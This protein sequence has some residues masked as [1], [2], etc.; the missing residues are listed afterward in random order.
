MTTLIYQLGSPIVTKNQDGTLSS[1]LNTALSNGV[2]PGDSATRY[3]T[4]FADPIKPTYSWNRSQRSS[5]DAFLAGT[6]AMYVAPASELVDTRAENPNLNYDVAAVPVT[7]GGGEQV[8]A[9]IQALAIP[10]GSKNLDGAVLVAEVLTSATQESFLANELDLPSPRRD[11]ELDASADAYRSTFRLAA[12]NSFV[13]ID[14]DPTV[15]DALFQ[16][17]VDAI[18][19]G[20]S[21]V[22][23]SVRKANDELHEL[24]RVQ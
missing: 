11:V 3:Y 19:S 18:S 12:I 6:L 1:V 20:R 9:D 24:T 17:M 13:F 8:Y 10:R 7:R 2:V 15:T 22:T 4:D 14:P 5:H 21:S 16:R 23:E